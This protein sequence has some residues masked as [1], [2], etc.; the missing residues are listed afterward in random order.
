MDA[1]SPQQRRYNIPSGR[2][3]W[4]KQLL[5]QFPDETEAIEKF[6]NLVD[7][8]TK[9]KNAFVIVKILPIWIV[10]LCDKLGLLNLFSDFFAFGHRTLKDVVE[11]GSTTTC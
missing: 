3:V 5:Q 7:R 4:K 11:V 9:A 1:G 2:G 8:I 10:R 6:F